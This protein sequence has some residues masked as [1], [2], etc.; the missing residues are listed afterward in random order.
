[1][2]SSFPTQNYLLEQNYGEEWKE[3][4]KILSDIYNAQ[5]DAYRQELTQ[6]LHE[7]TE[8]FKI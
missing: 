5:P 3:I 7:K 2:W 1:V 6:K 4:I 8:T